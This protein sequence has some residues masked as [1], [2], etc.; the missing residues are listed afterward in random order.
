M[1]GTCEHCS[2]T[3]KIE[4]F[5][6]GF[7]ESSH[8]YCDACGMTA[9]LSGWSK[10]WPKGVKCTQAEIADEM[11]S[12]LRAC[13]CGG[14]F[15]KGNSPRCPHCTQTLSPEKAAEYI[16]PQSPGS[17]KGWHWGRTWHGLYCAV[18]NDRSVADNFT[19][20]G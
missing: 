19:D 6:M 1:V 17:A 4:I 2:K 15:T 16:E 9:I 13:A 14:K 10:R 8:A 12:H 3:F 5:H 18:I 7:A 11:T 20:N